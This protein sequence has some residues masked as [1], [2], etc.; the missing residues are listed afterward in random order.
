[1]GTHKFQFIRIP[2][3]VL[4]DG[5][6]N[7]G[8][9]IVFGHILSLTQKYGYCFASN[10]YLSK[11]IGKSES[12]IQRSLR[13]LQKKEY[14]KKEFTH[15]GR[16][17]Y[18][19]YDG[20]VEVSNA[21]MMSPIME[22]QGVNFGDH[23]YIDIKKEE[24]NTI[25]NKETFFS[26]SKNKEIACEDVISNLRDFELFKTH[27]FSWGDSEVV[28]RERHLDKLS[29]EVVTKLKEE[30]PSFS[31]EEGKCIVEMIAENGFVDCFCSLIDKLHLI[32]TRP[33][34]DSLKNAWYKSRY[35]EVSYDIFKA[36]NT[37]KY[38]ISEE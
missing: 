31:V 36:F 22:N 29:G 13:I 16:R 2:F 7:D 8:D 4:G 6:L 23:N 19:D 1:M 15:K 5:D 10:D 17:I 18:I 28:F 27:L 38:L 11:L 24:N 30:L 32:G 34:G 3:Q 25:D 12:S 20:F 33:K 37:M 14:I 26:H 21:E 9:R 35:E